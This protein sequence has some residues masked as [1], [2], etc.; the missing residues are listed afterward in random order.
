MA[1]VKQVQPSVA[2][3]IDIWKK[4]VATVLKKPSDEQIKKIQQEAE[5]FSKVCIDD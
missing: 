5:K 4:I 3:N 2:E 1:T